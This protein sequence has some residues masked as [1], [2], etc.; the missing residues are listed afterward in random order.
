MGVLAVLVPLTL[1][2]GR[3][4]GMIVLFPLVRFVGVNFGAVLAI[5]FSLYEGVSDVLFRLLFCRGVV[6]HFRVVPDDQAGRFLIPLPYLFSGGIEIQKPDPPALLP[7]PTEIV[8]IYIHVSFA[9]WTSL[10]SPFTDRRGCCAYIN[11]AKVSFS[12][13]KT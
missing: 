2:G 5:L 13:K 3:G 8:K 7:V 1:S 6:V 10:Q 12:A 4:C 9:F 11:N